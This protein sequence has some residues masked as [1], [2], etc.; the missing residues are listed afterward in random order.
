MS[1]AKFIAPEIATGHATECYQ[2]NI[3][4][5]PVHRKAFFGTLH[6]LAEPWNWDTGEDEAKAAELATYWRALLHD[7]QEPGCGDSE[8]EDDAPYWD[9][10]DSMAGAG[11]G[12][13]WGYESIA[14][15]AITAFL[16]VAGS[17][18][19]ALFYRTTVPRVRLAFRS[20]DAGD[21]V[22]ILI[23]GILFGSVDTVSAVAGVPE[24][25]EI[26]IDLVE[27]AA[28][29]SLSGVERLIRLVAA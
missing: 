1:G 11:E 20:M 28:A 24:I 26:P 18:A 23:D 12:T 9:D 10:A 7:S 16:A 5:D 21:I 3:P 22:N 29:N 17:P 8:G 6:E 27:F 19:A 13:A 4:D 14:D 2:I 25:I 15:W